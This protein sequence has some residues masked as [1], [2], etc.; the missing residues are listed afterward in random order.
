MRLQLRALSGGLPVLVV[1][2]A[3]GWLLTG[4]SHMRLPH[5]GSH[6]EHSMVCTC[7]QGYYRGSQDHKVNCFVYSTTIIQIVQICHGWGCPW[8]SGAG[9]ITRLVRSRV[10]PSKPRLGTRSKNCAWSLLF[11]HHACWKAGHH[12]QMWLTRPGGLHSVFRLPYKLQQENQT[13]WF[14]WMKDLIAI[15]Y[16]SC[17]GYSMYWTN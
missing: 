3:V 10:Y 9:T 7:S 17:N 8:M 11:M 1:G 16:T 12:H 6:L 4:H 15:A 13:I 2:Q 14:I 5:S